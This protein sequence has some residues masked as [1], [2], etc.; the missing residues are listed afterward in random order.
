MIDDHQAR[1]RQRICENAQSFDDQQSI[2]EGN[3]TTFVPAA[4]QP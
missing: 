4:W 1:L 2:L 3:A